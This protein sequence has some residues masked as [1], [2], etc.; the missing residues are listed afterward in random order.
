MNL[1][2]ERHSSL[3][4]WLS[5]LDGAWEFQLDSLTPASS[6]ASSR[7]YWR[8]Q[9]ARGPVIVMDAPPA[10]SLNN[11]A[12]VRE[13][14]GETEALPDFDAPPPEAPPPAPKP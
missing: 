14:T 11:E 5:S 7:R 12:F 9:S 8:L 6:D 3:L 13:A 2:P 1:S 4:N 10:V